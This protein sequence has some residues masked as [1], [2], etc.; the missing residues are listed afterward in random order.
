M[1][2]LSLIVARLVLVLVAVE[3]VSLAY[4]GLV[5]GGLFYRLAPIQTADSAEEPALNAD[6]IIHPYFGFVRPPGQSVESVVGPGG[7]IHEM[8][9]QHDPLPDW[10]SI[11]TNNHG[12]WSAFDYPLHL[13][14]DTNFLVGIV[15]GSVAQ[16]LSLQ[17]GEYLGDELEKLPELEGRRAQVINLSNGGFKQPQQLMVL[18]YFLSIGQ[19]FDLVINLDGFNEVALPDAENRPK[20]VHHSLPR[21]YPKVVSSLTSI[22]DPAMIRWLAAGLELRE[23]SDRWTRRA[24]LRLSA[25]FHVLASTLQ[26]NF[27]VEAAKLM[28]A[29]PTIGEGERDVFFALA[30]G[31][32]SESSARSEQQFDLDLVDLWL[33]SSRLMHEMLEGSGARY[34]H[35][36]QPNQ[37]HSKKTF[38]PRE[39]QI[40]LRPEHPYSKA[41]ARLY[42]RLVERSRELSEGGVAF[43]DATRVFDEVRVDVYSD[44]CCHYNDVGNR[45]LVDLIV[46]EMGRDPNRER[47]GDFRGRELSVR[48][49]SSRSFPGRSGTRRIARENNEEVSFVS[50]LVL[51][52][53]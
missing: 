12:F 14:R 13:E 2:G 18:A 42:P 24:N 41:V 40:A 8:T 44:S 48:R 11:E 6:S 49:R 10:T 16:W 38:S 3:L 39:Q 47:V 5:E 17:A 7:R 25:T 53:E 22:A 33:H 20:D 26:R 19:R 45:I 51:V 21:S 50:P 37:Y 52:N 28:L 27:E 30:S 29:P 43:L 36:L 9:S 32:G 1:K 4:I 35:V 46:K 31:T 15:G 23:K 34:L